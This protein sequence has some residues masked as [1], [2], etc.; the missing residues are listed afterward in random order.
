MNTPTRDDLIWLREDEG[1]TRE[2]IAEYYEVSLTTVRRWIKELKVPRPTKQAR[3]QTRKP[4]TCFGGV[5]SDP[6]DGM[7]IMECAAQILGPR[8][9]ERRGVGYILDGRPVSSRRVVESAGLK[10]KDEM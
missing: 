1:M 9:T 7:T 6:Y 2:Q 3:N 4:L 8:L 10:F 5:V